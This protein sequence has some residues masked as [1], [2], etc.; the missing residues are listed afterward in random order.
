MGTV[1]RAT[2]E[3][4]GR[5]V[6]LKQM[7]LGTLE[8]AAMDVAR[9]RVLR[10]ARAA[11]SLHH[12]NAVTVFDVLIADGEPWLVLEY[13]PSRSLAEVLA[14]RGTLDPEEVARIGLGVSAALVAAHE[15]GIVHRDVKPANVLLGER[16]AVKLTD[17]G[18]ARAVGDAT[19]TSAG[20]LIGTPAFLA[21]EVAGGADA[22]A[23]S[24][25]FALGATLYAA[26]EGRPPF[27]AAADENVL[28]LL[29]RIATGEVPPPLRAGVLAE[30]LT[31][32]LALDP[33]ARPSAEQVQAALQEALHL[34]ERPAAPSAPVPEPAPERTGEPAESLPPPLPT[35]STSSTARSAR[36]V[37]TPQPLA[38]STASVR[39][40]RRGPVVTALSLVAVA[41][42]VTTAVLVGNS[43][44][45]GGVSGVGA[46][47]AT[48]AAAATPATS[49]AA[50][51]P[52]TSAAAATPA[53]AAPVWPAPIAPCDKSHGDLVVGMIAPLTG[54]VAALGTGMR[55]SVQLALDQANTTCKVAGYRLVLRA[56]DDV[57]AAPNAASAAG[58]LLAEPALVGVIG[59]LETS[60]VEAVQ[61][62]LDASGVVEI[63]PSTPTE[64]LTRGSEAL[65]HR[66]FPGYFRLYPTDRLQGYVA[67]DQVIGKD[68]RRRVAAVSDDT[69]WG[70]DLAGAFVGRAISIGG[71]VVA[72]DRIRGEAQNYTDAIARIAQQHPDAVYFGG[73]D[74]TAVRFAT[75]LRAAGVSVPLVGS[76]DVDTD[77]FLT[78]AGRDGDV[79]TGTGAPVEM[80][81]GG[82][83]FLTAYRSAGF[84][85]D[86]RR[87]G[88][89]AYDAAQVL[90]NGLGALT[91]GG[92]WDRSR[93][94]ELVAAVQR[95]DQA[96]VTGRLAFDE[97]GDARYPVYTIYEFR[98][99]EL[100]PTSLS[101]PSG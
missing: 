44:P 91:T 3:L 54:T 80:L 1:W 5:T 86:P 37:V 99:G 45:P 97:Y 28:A 23:A 96:G 83:P 58:S 71:Q 12:P 78:G 34:P 40:S 60:N 49:A 93:R 52:A 38:P 2:D 64:T 88:A 89:Y 10:E 9:Q 57:G 79:F 25:V 11:A 16:H 76:D 18:I 69:G 84:K 61:P 13:V 7:R 82:G 74:D 48:S 66:P 75:Q 41:A 17:F 30:P 33:A 39:R 81:D 85:E 43:R 27:S 19:L 70:D 101:R 73:K 8:P 14:E 22:T 31:A 72:R 95:T 59:P 26:V 4:L 51:T 6:A 15:R 20:M 35:S 21:P 32:M 94:Q 42:L 50:A 92:P 24:D 63:S 29:R 100:G 55:N 46:T 87:Y 65:P 98:R 53:P 68:Q 47:P 56:L 77:A 62:V 36:T 90:V 67:A